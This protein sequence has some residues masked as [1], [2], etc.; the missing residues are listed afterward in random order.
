MMYR[1]RAQALS[2]MFPFKM[3]STPLFLGRARSGGPSYCAMYM[4][5]NGKIERVEGNSYRKAGADKFVRGEFRNTPP[6]TSLPSGI[7]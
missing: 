5:G 1:A 6:T 7:T 3:A 4:R 2:S